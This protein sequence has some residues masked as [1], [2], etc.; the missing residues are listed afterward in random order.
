VANR[1]LKFELIDRQPLT[2]REKEYYRSILD[3]Y[4]AKRYARELPDSLLSTL[5]ATEYNP[6]YDDGQY[7]IY[8]TA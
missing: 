7:E 2:D 6:R 3:E 4:D 1:K 5:G 8:K